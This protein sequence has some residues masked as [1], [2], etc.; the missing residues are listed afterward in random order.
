M[1]AFFKLFTRIKA[2]QSKKKNPATLA[3]MSKISQPMS[4]VLSLMLLSNFPRVKILRWMNSNTYH[5][6]F[7]TTVEVFRKS[8]SEK[9]PAHSTY[10]IFMDLMEGKQPT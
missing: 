10:D 1:H 2:K 9:L 7:I 6:F 5:D 8:E 3:A 4:V